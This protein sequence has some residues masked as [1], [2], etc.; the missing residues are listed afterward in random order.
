MLL[1]MADNTS[2]YH[3]YDLVLLP[4]QNFALLLSSGI[5]A[6]KAL[7]HDRFGG[8]SH[9]NKQQGGIVRKEVHRATGPV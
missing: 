7:V 5:M 4:S 6:M 9:E 8:A 2:V 1:H 3:R